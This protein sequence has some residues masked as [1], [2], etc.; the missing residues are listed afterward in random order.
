MEGHD[1][2]VRAQ[3]TTK[4]W[5]LNAGEGVVV[6]EA[7]VDVGEAEQHNSVSFALHTSSWRQRGLVMVSRTYTHRWY[8][9]GAVVQR[10]ILASNY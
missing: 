5:L 2:K 7:V 10:Y 4:Q 1:G 9:D 3:S 8:I 6:E